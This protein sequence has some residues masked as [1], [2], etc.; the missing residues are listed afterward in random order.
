MLWEESSVN[1]L[2]APPT[3]AEITEFRLTDGPSESKYDFKDVMCHGDHWAQWWSFFRHRLVE[4][5]W[6]DERR[7][8]GNKPM[9]Q[10]VQPK[11]FLQQQMQKNVTTTVAPAFATHMNKSVAETNVDHQ[12]ALTKIS[13][14][15]PAKVPQEYATLLKM[16]LADGI[17]QPEEKVQ[18]DLLRKEKGISNQQ[19]DDA[20][21][22]IE[23]DPGFSH[24]KS[25]KARCE[26]CKTLV[27]FCTGDLRRNTADMRRNKGGGAEGARR[28]TLDLP[29]N[30]QN[31]PAPPVPIPREY[32]VGVEMA[33]A[34][35]IIQIEEEE[36]L[37]TMRKKTGVSVEQHAVAI[38]AIEAGN[39]YVQIDGA[40]AEIDL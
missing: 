4:E 17:I 40:E 14:S 20:V 19:H 9:A 21:R 6:V 7:D 39:G 26:K 8:R 31:D 32:A 22:A 3:A 24:I 37:A 11:Q 2:K 16:A 5:G 29:R 1:P 33:L 34:D 28:N 18:L 38:Q 12:L 30:T 10:Q 23:A 36:M 35:G 15:K 27:K 25:A 13:Q